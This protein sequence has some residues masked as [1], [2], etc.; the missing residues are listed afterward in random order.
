MV[1]K[2]GGLQK[3]RSLVPH[4]TMLAACGVAFLFHKPPL[5]FPLGDPGRNPFFHLP[6]PLAESPFK[7][8][9]SHFPVA[10]LGTVLRC[11]NH[12][13]G[14]EVTDAHR[15]IRSIAVLATGTGGAEKFYLKVRLFDLH[16]HTSPRTANL[17]GVD[18]RPRTVP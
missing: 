10:K 9:Q 3:R 6:F 14:R 12:Y 11:L 5:L 13:T 2:L 16:R 7:S 17:P 18:S 15:R 8:L 4:L 1:K